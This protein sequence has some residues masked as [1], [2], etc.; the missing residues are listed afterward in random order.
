MTQAPKPIS[1]EIEG[2]F[3]VAGLD[4]PFVF[5]AQMIGGALEG[6]E[7]GD[8]EIAFAPGGADREAPL[9]SALCHLF[10]FGMFRLH[11]EL[12][13]GFW[14]FAD[15]TRTL[16]RLAGALGEAGRLKT[17]RLY[18]FGSEIRFGPRPPILGQHPL[19]AFDL[20]TAA[21]SYDD[22]DALIDIPGAETRRFGEVLLVTRALEAEAEDDY[23]LAIQPGLMHLARAAKPGLTEYAL[24]DLPDWAQ[25]VYQTGSPALRPVGYLEDRGVVE[26]SCALN[27]GQHVLHWE[28]DAL[29]AILEAGRLRDGRPVTEVRIVFLEEAEARAESRPLLDNRARVLF[30]DEAGA[31]VEVA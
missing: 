18:R 4:D 24:P 26:L 25:A 22:L 5:F 21:E 9:H 12:V 13:D 1:L 27:P 10:D 3:N 28:V 2:S 29:R 6:G 19:V 7:H 15:T 11:M 8:L 16:V 30:Y 17:A 20:G 31:L 23:L 14:R